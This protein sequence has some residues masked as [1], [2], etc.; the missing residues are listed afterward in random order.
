ME[1]FFDAADKSFGENESDIYDNNIQC[2]ADESTDYL[3]KDTMFEMDDRL[4]E[5]GL[6]LNST[7]ASDYNGANAARLS[8]H[9]L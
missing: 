3:D 7:L 8:A 6:L 9:F 5:L 4:H 1:E 2:I